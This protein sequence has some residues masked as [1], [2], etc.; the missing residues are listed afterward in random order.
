M[1]AFIFFIYAIHLSVFNG[2]VALLWFRMLHANL[3]QT[4]CVCG[5]RQ[6]CYVC[7]NGLHMNRFSHFTLFVCLICSL[8][9]CAGGGSD[10]CDDMVGAWVLKK[11]I[12]PTGYE[13]DYP[14][15]RGYTR[16]KIYDNDSTF[17]YAELLSVDDETMILPL[18]FERY[19]F[20]YDEEDTL[21][22]ENGRFMRHFRL[23]CD[24]VY[25]V[26]NNLE[27]EVWV[28]SGQ[29]TEGRKNEI[30]SAVRDNIGSGEED[31]NN[32]VFSTSEKRLMRMNQNMLFLSLFLV[33]MALMLVVYVRRVIKKSKQIK[34]ELEHIEELNRLRPQPVAQAIRKVESDFFSSEYYLAFRARLERGDVLKESELVELEQQIKPLYPDFANRLY[35]LYN[36]S[37]HEYH[38]CLLLKVNIPPVLIASALCREVSSISSTRSRLYGK[39]F[40]KKGSS[41]EWDAFISTL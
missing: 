40:G 8:Y 35:K 5:V 1:V 36:M 9:S 10:V 37:R 28:K 11:I 19:T 20:I 26:F 41:K 4:V 30:R 29:M 6:N 22:V 32:F 15:A 25:T 12:F 2:F 16:C 38:V 7:K 17:Y 39:V 34:L 33:C 27:Q 24:T 3:L 31:S 18:E 23:V 13:A 14:N 21:L